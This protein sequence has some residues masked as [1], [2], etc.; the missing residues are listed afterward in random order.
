MGEVQQERR[1][2]WNFVITDT[3]WLWTV[4]RPDGTEERADRN[5]KTLKE[6][7]DDAAEH[8]YGSWKQEERRNVDSSF[9]IV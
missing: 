8:G 9:G 3:G 5:F 2:S 4:T 1:S 7:A 6:C